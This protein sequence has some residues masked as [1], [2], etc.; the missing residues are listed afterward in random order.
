MKGE[1]HYKGKR[2]TME[3]EKERHYEGREALWRERETMKG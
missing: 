3:G 2:D 1:K